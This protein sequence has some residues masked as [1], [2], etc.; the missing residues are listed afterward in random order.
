MKI[1]KARRIVVKKVSLDYMGQGC[2]SNSER[3]TRAQLVIDHDQHIIALR[4][5]SGPDPHITAVL[6]LLAHDKDCIE[7]YK[8]AR[9]FNDN[10]RKYDTEVET[11]FGDSGCEE[12]KLYSMQSFEDQFYGLHREMAKRLSFLTPLSR[13][14][15]ACMRVTCGDS[16]PNMCFF[17]PDLILILENKEFFHWKWDWN[18]YT[19]PEY[20]VMY[21]YLECHYGIQDIVRNGD[22][23][24]FPPVAPYEGDEEE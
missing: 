20:G 4:K 9:W 10:Q 1:T 24:Y 2:W 16:T 22:H 21:K 8:W 14:E 6:S 18:K 15:V 17:A 23:Y 13:K 19:D 11:Y 5:T 3:A 7:E 12:Y